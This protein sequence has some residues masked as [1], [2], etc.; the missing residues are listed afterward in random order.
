MPD[1]LVKLY[2][3]PPL[4]PV[5]ERQRAQEID[6]RR[7]MSS[8]KSIIVQWAVENF[9]AG[10]GDE[11]AM[12]MTQSPPTCF[13]A[14]QAGE[15]LGFACYDSTQKGF[16]GPTG[17]DKTQRGKGV[18]TALLVAT[19]HAMHWAG[20]GYAI[21]GWVGPAEYY[22]RAVGATLIPD[23]SPGVY[24]GLLMRNKDQTES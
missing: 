20:Y 13:I 7:A 16:F 4:E 24:Q 5:L 8:E 14:T 6:I 12:A 3:L 17:V 11:C 21:I 18:G 23:S 15:L 10:W 19:L 9:S 22:A 2:E 1:M